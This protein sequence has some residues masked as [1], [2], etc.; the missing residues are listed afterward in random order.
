[1]KVKFLRTPAVAPGHKPEHVEGDTADL[2]DD[3]AKRLIA[4]GIAEA[5]EAKPGAKGH[6]K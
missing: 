1:M 3:E 2:P 6:G 4:A 5:D